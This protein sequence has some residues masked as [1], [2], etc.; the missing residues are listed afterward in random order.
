M[1]SGPSSGGGRAAGEEPD[2]PS[3]GGGATAGEARSQKR[4]LGESTSGGGRAAGETTGETGCE[5]D[6]EMS[7]A[8]EQELSRSRRRLD[9][10]L[11]AIHDVG[12]SGY[13]SEE[14]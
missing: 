7:D 12:A 2:E 13:A 14:E 10:A 6:E 5:E 8:E 4:D 3:L 11:C 9:M 1:P